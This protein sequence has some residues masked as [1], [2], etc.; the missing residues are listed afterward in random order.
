MTRRRPARTATTCWP[1]STCEHSARRALGGAGD[2]DGRWH[3]PD[4]DHPDEHPSVTMQVDGD[5]V[6]RWRCWSGGH[7]G[8]AI[9]AVMAAHHVD[10][11]GA[12]RW[13]AERYTN[14]PITD[15]PP[16][17]P[18]AALGHPD[19]ERRRVRGAGGPAVVDPG[20][21][22]PTGTGWPPAASARTC[23]APTGSAPTRA[24]ATCPARRGCPPAGRPSSTRH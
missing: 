9:D 19:P 18:P 7:G 3:C 24:V 10:A 13:L 20:R 15:R 14:L 11:G 5:G 22:P 2:G 17:T 1:E 12:I 6:Q 16:P 4:R 21:A 8:T 23:C